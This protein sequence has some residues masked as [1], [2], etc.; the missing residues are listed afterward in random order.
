[1]IGE[2]IEDPKVPQPR[3]F[4]STATS[5]SR[6]NAT[7]I[8]TTRSIDRN[9]S[10]CTLP[11]V[12]T[13]TKNISRGTNNVMEILFGNTKPSAIIYRNSVSFK[14][15]SFTSSISPRVSLPLTLIYS[16]AMQ[17][18]VVT[19]NTSQKGLDVKNV[20]ESS[21]TLKAFSV[22]TMT[23]AICLASAWAPPRMHPFASNSECFICQSQFAVFHRACHCRNCGVC[24]CISC[25]VQWP[26]KMI[27][28]TYNIKNEDIVNIC[29]ACDWL[30]SAFRLALLKGESDKAIALHATGNVNLMTPF[31]Y[32][33][34]E[35]L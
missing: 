14:M 18:W 5:S 25:T 11:S 24:I 16:K 21:K 34:G 3:P 6:N 8:G 33:K 1:M 35:V 9:R 22:P 12:Q 30:C 26:S 31:A 10:E 15:D 29:K 17:S 13:L 20:E 27:P 19:L 2:C 32:I 23:Q 4:S 7:S 28:A